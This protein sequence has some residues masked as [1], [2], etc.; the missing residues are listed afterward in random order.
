M[1]LQRDGG[2]MG[3]K[4]Q[5]TSIDGYICSTS[6]YTLWTRPGSKN[7]LSVLSYILFRNIKN[8]RYEAHFTTV[9]IN[10]NAMEET[11]LA[12]EAALTTTW[13]M[14]ACRDTSR[15]GA[16]PMSSMANV[17]N[18]KRLS[19]LV[20]AHVRTKLRYMSFYSPVRLKVDS[21][22]G[23]VIYTEPI[24]LTSVPIEPKVGILT[25]TACLPID[26]AAVVAQIR[27]S[28]GP[29]LAKARMA[30]AFKLDMT[31][32]HH[33]PN[34]HIYSLEVSI[35]TKNAKYSRRY[36]DDVYAPPAKSSC[37]GDSMFEIIDR[38]LFLDGRE[39]SIRVLLPNGFD[40]LVACADGFSALSVLAVY[41]HWHETIYDMRKSCAIVPIF[42]YVGPELYGRGEEHDYFF[43]VGFPGWPTLK[44]KASEDGIKETVSTYV[45]L[46]GLWPMSGGMALH[47]LAPWAPE[48]RPGNDFGTD[49][50][51]VLAN[52]KMNALREKWPAGRMTCVLPHGTFIDGAHVVQMDFSAFTPSLYLTLYPSHKR[53]EHAVRARH[54]R[55]KPWL[56]KALVEF[57]GMLKHTHPEAL[58]AT[59]AISNAI[60]EA[61][62]ETATANGLAIC[63]YIKDGFWGVLP[64][65][66]NQRPNDD[67]VNICA[68]CQKAA[69]N[70]LHDLH[71][72]RPTGPGIKLRVEEG[73]YTH[74]MS[75]G[76][77]HYWLGGV[78]SEDYKLVGFP[79]RNTFSENVAK[80][81]AT[82]LSCVA[83][84][85]NYRILYPLF[86]E[87]FDRLITTAF[88]NRNDSTFW[89]VDVPISD[90][91][92]PSGAFSYN[93]H[94]D[95]D[96]GRRRVVEVKT[97]S[98]PVTI[99][100]SLLPGPMIV[101]GI[102]CLKYI[103][104]A[105]NSACSILS[106]AVS[107]KWCNEDVEAFTYDVEQ[108]EPLFA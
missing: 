45:D 69:E 11:S 2:F 9:D 44:A 60:S 31:K 30:A 46:D 54:K 107:S 92:I 59:I 4:E 77:H 25:A 7:V 56:K 63:T 58:D 70:V 99:P 73:T 83:A 108:F 86:K 35:S 96:H 71:L 43:T 104:P 89:S 8:S 37:S 90:E 82:L 40:C 23:L 80:T 14:T 57:C 94:M 3:T 49:V 16:W 98:E 72:L 26:N 36:S 17:G 84:N 5:F 85:S 53:L 52:A 55:E 61:I 87:A 18:W 29:S 21:N 66:N 50:V 97:F 12:E 28:A 39:I 93:D 1:E 105:L 13:A 91:P 78:D 101:P 20:S 74:A 102:M 24:N 88:E 33:R 6:I 100:C 75:L 41:R 15:P 27:S 106:H 42:A 48:K 81:V 103:R 34:D 67:I 51:D 32:S 22:T 19:C 62:E 95:M 47:L 76:M 10:L 38:T 64:K 65:E 68:L 79:I